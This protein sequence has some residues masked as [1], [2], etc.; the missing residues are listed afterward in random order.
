MALPVPVRLL[1]SNRTQGRKKMW[2]SGAGRKRPQQSG[3]S[4][5]A[6]GFPDQFVHQLIDGVDAKVGELSVQPAALG[7]RADA[8]GRGRR[9]AVVLITMVRQRGVPTRRLR[10]AHRGNQQNPLSSRKTKYAL[11]Q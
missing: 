7:A 4:P 10:P 9:D 1:Q 11:D 5:N 2:Q 6:T 8:H 3:Q